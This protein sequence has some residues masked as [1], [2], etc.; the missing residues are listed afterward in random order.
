[1]ETAELL[2]R[3]LAKERGITE[4][5]MFGG[6]CFLLDGNMLAGTG[7]KDHVLFRVGKAAHA[8]A[9]KRPGAQPMIHGGHL[10]EGFIWVEAGALV[11]D[12][13]ETWL[14]IAKA[15]VEA[16]PPKPQKPKKEKS[17]AK[18]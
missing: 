11:G 13:L 16:L 12:S 18:R 9:V 7:K 4:K 2:R 17:R 10:M 5:K 3:A 15:N 1:M 8:A 14:A 6:V